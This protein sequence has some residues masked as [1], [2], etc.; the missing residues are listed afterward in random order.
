VLTGPRTILMILP[1]NTL[2]ALIFIVVA[3][4]LP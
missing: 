2:R 3:P 1:E 4:K